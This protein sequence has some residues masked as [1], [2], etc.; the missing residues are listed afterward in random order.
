MSQQACDDFFVKFCATPDLQLEYLY[1]V[2][3]FQRNNNLE[4][5]GIELF[6]ATVFSQ[7]GAKH[8]Y[9]FTPEEALQKCQA[10]TTVG[11]FGI[12]GVKLDQRVLDVLAAGMLL[13]NQNNNYNNHNNP[14]NRLGKSL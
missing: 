3:A 4:R 2:R 8:G 11:G 13:T 14:N 6:E 7:V 1:D 5:L 10:I 9:Q 12:K